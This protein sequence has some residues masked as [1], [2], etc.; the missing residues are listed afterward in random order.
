MRKCIRINGVVMAYDRDK[1]F[2]TVALKEYFLKVNE[3]KKD[4]KDLESLQSSTTSDPGYH[5]GK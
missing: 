1:M 5:M 3:S 2:H 4:G